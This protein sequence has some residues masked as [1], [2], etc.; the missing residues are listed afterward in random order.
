MGAIEN[1]PFWVVGSRNARAV[2][3]PSVFD[4]L[5]G[6]WIGAPIVAL[7]PKIEPQFARRPFLAVEETTTVT[8]EFLKGRHAAIPI[9]RKYTDPT[10]KK[11][12]HF[13]YYSPEWMTD[14][15][16]FLLW[17]IRKGFKMKPIEALQAERLRQI[18]EEGYDSAHDDERK[19]GELAIAAA[20]YASLAA[21]GDKGTLARDVPPIEWP[22]D[23]EEWK[24]DSRRRMLVKAG[25]LILAE[26]A[27]LDR[28][29]AKAA[30]KD[31]PFEFELPSSVEAGIP[32]G[33]VTAP[34]FDDPKSPVQ[35]ESGVNVKGV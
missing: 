19:R 23:S 10:A 22:L 26:L 12:H 34:T 35:F 18:T 20:A 13:Y 8:V 7:P 9:N 15:H 25:A 32:A 3:A 2:I 1:F 29:E 33:G 31:V 30:G 16:S 14:E 24:P 27:R 11:A 4:H 17:K 5:K 6:D 28:E 21:E